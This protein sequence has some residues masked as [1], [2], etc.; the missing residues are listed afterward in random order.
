MA[1]SILIHSIRKL[2]MMTLG[3]EWSYVEYCLHWVSHFYCFAEGWYAS[4]FVTN[5]VMLSIMA[6]RKSGEV[7]WWQN[8]RWMKCHSTFFQIYDNVALLNFACIKSG[9]NSHLL[10]I[11]F[12][13]CSCQILNISKYFKVSHCIKKHL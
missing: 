7:S 3:T 11:S 1:L 8:V 2:S 4:V 10:L 13:K 9:L 6:P 12:E 5:V